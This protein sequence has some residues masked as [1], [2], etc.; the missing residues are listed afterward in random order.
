MDNSCPSFSPFFTPF[1]KHPHSPFSTVAGGEV[2][3]GVSGWEG[4]RQSGV[5]KGGG[6]LAGGAVGQVRGALLGT[7]ETDGGGD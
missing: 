6:G 1:H 4:W 7:E 3:G 5:R 2:Y